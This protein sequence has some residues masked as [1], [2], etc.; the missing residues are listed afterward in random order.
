MLVFFDDIL[1]YS[2]SWNKH[3]QHLQAVFQVLLHHQ[4]FV[5]HSKCVFG[6]SRIEYLGHVISSE[7]VDMDADK[8][9]C[10]VNWPYPKTVKDVRGFLELTGYYQRFVKHYGTIAQPITTLLKANCFVE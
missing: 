2:A 10:I 4:L 9:A 1:I 5:K 6:T 7:G 8:V 3:L